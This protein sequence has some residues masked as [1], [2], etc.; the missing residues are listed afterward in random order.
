LDRTV[1]REL[2]RIATAQHGV[3]T[4]A[5]LLHA[6]VTGREVA[7]RVRTGALL[8]EHRGV[9]RVGHRAPTVEASYLAA[10]LAAGDGAALSGHAAAHLWGLVRGRAPQAEAITRTE[11]RIE[12]V[13]TS[14]CR[15]LEARDVTVLNGIPLTTVARTLVDVAGE[16]SAGQLARACHEAGVRYGTSPSNVAEVLVRRPNS[17]GSRQLRRVMAG[18]VPVTLSPLESRFLELLREAGLPP[19]ITNRRADGHRVDCRW[20][21]ARLTVELDSYRFHNSRHSWERDRRRER[22]ARARGDDFRRFSY[23]EVVDHPALVLRELG[24]FFRGDRPG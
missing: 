4:R 8:R 21:E 17:P 5:Q 14:R 1:E 16:L 19:P 9:Y 13:K 20:P 2:G 7:S 15:R 12:G 10:V 24:A 22:E 11:R 6:G 3:V 18:D 23:G